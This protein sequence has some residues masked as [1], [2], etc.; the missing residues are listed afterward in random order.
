MLRSRVS[1]PCNRTRQHP[2]LWHRSS[3]TW[4]PK[5]PPVVHYFVR[6][7][8]AGLN[9][10][11]V[12]ACYPKERQKFVVALRCGWWWLWY[13]VVVV[14][15]FPLLISPPGSNSVSSFPPPFA[16]HSV[17]LDHTSRL[18]GHLAPFLHLIKELVSIMSP[19][20][21]NEEEILQRRKA[22]LLVELQDINARL[23]KRSKSKPP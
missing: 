20:G 12:D 18:S 4:S 15:L 21:N 1:T 8:L 3:Y 9:R 22:R 7:A 2:H 23:A 11:F 10:V 19:T 14:L 6:R 13:F 16:A 5:T 17:L